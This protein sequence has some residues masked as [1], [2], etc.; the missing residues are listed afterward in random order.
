MPSQNSR[1]LSQKGLADKTSSA[2][3]GRCGEAVVSAAP[4]LKG[5]LCRG[6]AFGA[7]A[8]LNPAS[9]AAMWVSVELDE[10][11]RNRREEIEAVAIVPDGDYD[12]L[13]SD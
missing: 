6:C 11:P 5:V 8:H 1:R 4:G 3:C 7:A 10:Q 2:H 12:G 9:L 13:D